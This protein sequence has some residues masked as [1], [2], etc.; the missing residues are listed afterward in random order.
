MKR[1]V[2]AKLESTTSVR[3][4]AK[5]VRG[6]QSWA[7]IYITLGFVIAVELTIIPLLLRF[8][9]NVIVLAAVMAFTFY[10]FAFNGWFQNKLMGLKN[11][12]ENKAR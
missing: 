12:Y 2:G 9:W 5:V 1:E 3:A 10:L 4:D 8:P 6:P 7:Y 11:A